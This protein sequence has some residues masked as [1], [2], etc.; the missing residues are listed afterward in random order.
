MA[1]GGWR[2]RVRVVDSAGVSVHSA[3]ELGDTS[4]AGNGTDATPQAGTVLG[5]RAVDAADQAA[6]TIVALEVEVTR[7]AGGINNDFD[8]H[9]LT[10][11]A[12]YAAA[13]AAGQ[14][15]VHLPFF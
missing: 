15:Q 5:S 6:G 10:L 4:I 14:R 9:D 13:A 1:A 2:I 11:V 12:T 3:G 7:T 8:V